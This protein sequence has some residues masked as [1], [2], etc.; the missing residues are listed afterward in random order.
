MT[1]SHMAKSIYIAAQFRVNILSLLLLFSSTCAADTGAM[2]GPFWSHAHYPLISL[3]QFPPAGRLWTPSL[4]FPWVTALTM[5][6][7]TH[8]SQG[9]AV[10]LHTKHTYRHTTILNIPLNIV[11]ETTGLDMTCCIWPLESGTILYMQG[12]LI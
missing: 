5:F 9:R 7:V 2:C 4:L 3:G 1:S 11:S 8:G 12:L 10:K 6:W